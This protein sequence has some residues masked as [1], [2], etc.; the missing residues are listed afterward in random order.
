MDVN[1]LNWNW[2]EKKAA[3]RH[4]LTYA[5]GLVTMAAV[6]GLVS[7]GDASTLTQG[8]NDIGAGLAQFAK[9]VAAIAGVLVPLYSALMAKRSAQPDQ[10]IKSVV[11]TLSAPNSG[12]TVAEVV[13]DE[14]DRKKLISAV[15]DM[16]EVKGVVTTAKVADETA[17]NKVVAT[18]AEIPVAR[19]GAS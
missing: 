13:S 12:K 10:Q 19:S 1:P 7:Q 5:G 2:N 11:A 4:V 17:S 3:G 8:L 18:A 9:G 16:P 6:W 14:S 15:A